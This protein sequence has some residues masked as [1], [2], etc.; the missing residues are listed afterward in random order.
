MN[1]LKTFFITFLLLIATTLTRAQKSVIGVPDIQ[2]YDKNEYKSGTQN[3]DIDQD[4]N[5]NIYF[6]NQ[7]GLLQFDGLSWRLYKVA[8]CLKVRSVKF[9]N[10]TGRIYVGGY[11]EFGYFESDSKGHLVY[12]SLS[13]LVIDSDFVVSD[14][15]WKIHIY[16]DEIIFQSFSGIYIY[17]NNEINSL[18]A[19]NRFQFS[20]KTNDKLFFQDLKDG[21]LEYKNGFL[22]PLKGTDVLNDTEIWGIFSMPNEQYLITTLENGLFIYNDEKVT[23]WDTEANTFI[24]K[25]GSLGGVSL[26]NNTYILNS[27]LNGTI[28]CDVNGKVIQHLNIKKGLQNNTVLKSFIDY[29]NDLWLGLDNG[30]S[31]VDKDSPFTFF[32]ANYN[33]STVYAS[34]VYEG[35]LY[36]AT[37]Q[38]V[39]YLELNTSFSN[40]NFTLLK[41]ITAQSWNL[42]VIGNELICSNNNGAFII[43]EKKVIRKIDDKGY[44]GFK[45]FPSNPNYVIAAN[46]GGFSLFE[47]RENGIKYISPIEGF[48][49]STIFF[50]LDDTFLWLLRDSNLYKMKLDEN[51]KKITSLEKI[52]Q[53][54][55]TKTKINSLQKIDG[56]V[57][58]EGN[59]QFYTYNK[60]KNEFIEEFDLSNLFKNCLP[61]HYVKEDILGNLWYAFDESLGVHLKDSFGSYKNSQTIFPNLTGNLVHDYLSINTFDSKNIFIGT[62]NG[63]A[64]YN[65]KFI[66]DTKTKPKVNIRSFTYAKGTIILGNPSENKVAYTMSYAQNNVKFTFSSPEFDNSKNLAFSFQ[67]EPF[68]NEWSNWSKNAIKEYTNLREGKYVMKV[69]TRNSFGKESNVKALEFL[70]NPP[71]YRHYIA[72]ILYFILLLFIIHYTSVFIKMRYRKREYY[73]TIEQRKIYLEKESKIRKEQYHLEKQIQKLNKEKLQT[74][75]RAQNKELVNNSL[76]MVKKNKILN[77]IIENLTAMEVDSFNEKNKILFNSLKK[78]IIKEINSDNSWKDLEK[79][80]KNVHFEFLKRLKEKCPT[81]SPRELDLST[82]LLMNMTTKEISEVMNIS[83][84]SASVSRYRLRKKLRLE[85]DQNLTGYLLS[86]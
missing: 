68:D 42:Q 84:K 38:G 83:I 29:K 7:N 24:K 9:D 85:R 33:L 23:S 35:V 17:K 72:Y 66:L 20:F 79:H 40:H 15:I 77:K 63:L 46:Y 36:A 14:Y 6:A 71:W 25:N 1:L 55:P 51:H 13:D 22:A 53:L 11:S 78:S 67:L 76:Q 82:Y 58:F 28:T 62:T 73:K 30:I 81:I 18:R 31:F 4:D 32:D 44:Y 64:N 54:N 75:L 26:N 65:S 47:I 19:P 34:I 41:G 43:K 5:G 74:K 45:K 61:I 52:V 8:N 12:T 16:N 37:N 27:V 49:N 59:N 2:N 86:I 57:I 48:N 60:D 10:K 3:W 39:F 21:I 80:I 50:E 70:I 56:K 69:K